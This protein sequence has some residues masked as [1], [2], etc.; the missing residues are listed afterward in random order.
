MVGNPNTILVAD[1]D[2]SVVTGIRSWLAEDYRI[3]TT[4]DGDDALA[5]LD[6]VD[7]VLVGQGLR[8]AAGTAV[9]AEVERR[10]ATGTTVTL[11]SGEREDSH[12]V[13]GE[14]LVKPLTKADL[15]ETVDCLMRRARYDE[16]MAECT[17]LA[18]KR[19][20]V[21]ARS[22]ADDSLECDAEHTA[23]ERRLEAVFSEL[24]ELVE[25]FDSDDFRAAFETCTV[26]D[27]NR[28]RRASEL[29]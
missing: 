15:R 7:V 28:P 19:G 5:G 12:N 8:T 3:E 20:T 6:D 29:S 4:T 21:E 23:L 17:T 10:T 14:T 25:S 1:D 13:A 24:D 22:N 18:A 11:R 16:L 26:G 2:P 27:A 9:A